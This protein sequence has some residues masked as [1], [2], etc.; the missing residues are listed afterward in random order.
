MDSSSDSLSSRD[1]SD[2][3]NAEGSCN[4]SAASEDSYPCTDAYLAYSTAS[5]GDDM[6]AT[7]TQRKPSA[8]SQGSALAGSLQSGDGSSL[9]SQDLAELE[10]SGMPVPTG[11]LQT[12]ASNS[13]LE[14]RVLTSRLI[15]WRVVPL[16]SE[17]LIRTV[18]MDVLGM[19]APY[20]L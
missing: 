15:A 6:L 5:T 3:G 2:S 9:D 4:Q 7:A 1:R 16:V 14:S 19:T 13:G 11:G 20:S 10:S 8:E 18:D 12:E 17:N